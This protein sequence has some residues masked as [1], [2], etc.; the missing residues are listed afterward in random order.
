[1]KFNEKLISLR[2]GVAVF[3]FLALA[4]MMGMLAV[5]SVMA[6]GSTI[7]VQKLVPYVENGE[8][9]VDTFDATGLDARKVFWYLEGSDAR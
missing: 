2:V 4:G 9:P 8:Q 6:Q 3:A 7:T 5:Q 1:M